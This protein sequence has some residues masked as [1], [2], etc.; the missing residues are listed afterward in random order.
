M[1]CAGRGTFRLNE[2]QLRSFVKAVELK[3][4]SRAAE[5]SYISTPAFVQQINLLE[6][7]LGFS[8]FHRSS[9]G[10]RLTE[11]GEVFYA[12]AVEILDLYEGACRQGL[13][14]QQAKRS[15]LRIG[16]PSMHL[17]GFV[18]EGCQVFQNMYPDAKLD[19][20]PSAMRRHLNNLRSGK[21][22]LCFLA[23]PDDAALDGLVFHPLSQERFSFCM[24]K[25]HPLAGREMLSRSDLLLYPILCGTYE[26][27]KKPFTDCLPEGADIRVLSEEY[28]MT[29]QSR[30]MLSEEM[31]MI[32]SHWTNLYSSLLAVV[33]SELPA[34]RIGA[35]SVSPV[36]DNVSRFLACI[37]ELR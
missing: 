16:C 12:A 18:L 28:D 24:R 15:L 5:N 13:A 37:T 8:L 11:A 34:G 26:Y 33:P 21:I 7:G 32:H 1:S 9:H 36:P 31:I 22:D 23:E 19:L 10:V 30:S 14:L 6:E 25:S 27:L 3:S 29:T 20:I 4:F 35:V 2:R 17:P